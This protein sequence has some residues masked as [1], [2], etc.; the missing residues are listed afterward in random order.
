MHHRHAWKAQGHV[1]TKIVVQVIANLIKRNVEVRRPE[2][3][4]RRWKNFDTH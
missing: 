2:T 1:V 4:W 3:Y